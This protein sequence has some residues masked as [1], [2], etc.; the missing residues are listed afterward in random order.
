MTLMKVIITFTVCCDNLWKGKFLALEKPG[1]L[2]EF[3][4]YYFVATL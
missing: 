2:S 3:S 1:K 4:F